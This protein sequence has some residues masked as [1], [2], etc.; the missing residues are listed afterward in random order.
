LSVMD[1]ADLTERWTLFGGLRADHFTYTL[2]TYGI[3]RTTG[4]PVESSYDYSDTLTNAHLGLTYQLQPDAIVYASVASSTDINGGESDVGTNSGYGGAIILDGQIAGA[5]PERS[6]NIELGTKWDLLDHKLLTTAALFRTVKSDVMEGS[7]YEAVG[8]FNSGK[9]RVQGVEFSLVGNL[10]PDLTVQAGAAF[11]TS[12][13]LASATDTN[14]GKPL[15]NFADRSADVML[16]YRLTDWFSVGGSVRYEGE[17][18]A[19]QPDTAA[20]IDDNGY[21][22]QPV[23]SY[24]VLDLFGSWRISQQLEARFNLLNATDKDYY[25]AAYRSG[26]FLYKGD[27]RALRVTLDYAF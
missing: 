11:M 17:R 20:G 4:L 25:L 26:A 3:D 18:C 21:C 7:G 8:T 10:S 9:N 16:K 5:S 19:G 12:K 23:P 1:T 15:A 2:G 22:T 24:T 13:V 6:R 14:V 27:A